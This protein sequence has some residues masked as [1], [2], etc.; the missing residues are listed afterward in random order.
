M[1]PAAEGAALSLAMDYPTAPVAGAVIDSERIIDWIGG[2]VVGGIIAILIGVV[3]WVIKR[4]R[5]PTG[6]RQMWMETVPRSLV[7]RNLDEPEAT[8]ISMQIN[9]Q[10]V[11]SPY[12][13]DLYLWYAGEDDLPREAFDGGE[14]F[15]IDLACPVLHAERITAEGA[16]HNAELKKKPDTAQLHVPPGLYRAGDLVHYRLI[17]EG[18]PKHSFY[19]KVVNLDYYALSTQLWGRTP[20]RTRLVYMAWAFFILAGLAALGSIVLTP[21]GPFIESGVRQ[22]MLLL[23]CPLLAMAGF[24][25]LQVRDVADRRTRRAS[26]IAKKSLGRRMLSRMDFLPVQRDHIRSR[27]SLLQKSASQDGKMI[28]PGDA[29]AAGTTAGGSDE[30][31]ASTERSAP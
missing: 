23:A 24:T 27:Q 19:S 17:T 26:K 10:D 3:T 6:A 9:D 31:T 8:A 20:R 2:G 28:G 18:V 12:V 25:V 21:L 15:R 7:N 22:A 1:R 14:P 29:P 16:L 13:V 5:E 11:A 4:R 30:A